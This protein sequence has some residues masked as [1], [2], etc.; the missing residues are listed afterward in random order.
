MQ[1]RLSP[2]AAPQ[3]IARLPEFEALRDAGEGDQEPRA[4]ESRFL[5]RDASRRNVV[6][7]GGQVH[8]CRTAAG[9]ARRRSGDL[10]RASAPRP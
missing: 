6:A 10:P 8:W 2:R 7:Q 5:S 1:E 4:R 9:G 3:A